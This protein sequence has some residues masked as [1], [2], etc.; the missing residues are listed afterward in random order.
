MCLIDYWFLRISDWRRIDLIFSDSNQQRHK[1]EHAWQ[2]AT[3]S[4]FNFILIKPQ[5]QGKLIIKQPDGNVKSDGGRVEI[6]LYGVCF[7]SK[8]GLFAVNSEGSTSAFTFYHYFF[9]LCKYAQVI[10]C[11]V[12]L[13]FQFTNKL[14]LYLCKGKTF[15]LN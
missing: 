2:A 12:L 5:H 6:Y 15:K 13:F 10:N 11:R 8:S 1:L 4:L 9:L 3:C 14:V 7:I